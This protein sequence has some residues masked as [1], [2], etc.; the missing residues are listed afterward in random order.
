MKVLLYFLA[1]CFVL[2]GAA[3]EVFACTCMHLGSFQKPDQKMIDTKR[4][5]A[6]AVFSGKVT[7]IVSSASKGTT[8]TSLKVYIKVIKAWK[9]VTTE[10]VV[11]ST[12]KGSNF[13]GFPFKVNEEYLVY[14]YGKKNDLS[15]D[16][17]SRTTTLENAAKD[18][19]FL[20][21]AKLNFAEKKNKKLPK[22][23]R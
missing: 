11:V 17:C 19:E 12:A 6:N 18:I 8:I 1:V 9:G 14:S 7:K 23:K 2:I 5:N 13:C 21:E 3:G 10:N 22:N 16:I 15:T 20:G 4:D